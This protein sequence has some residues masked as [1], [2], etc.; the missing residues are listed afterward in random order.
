MNK[1]RWATTLVGAAVLAGA[2]STVSAQA[3][4]PAMNHER[5]AATMTVHHR[6][7][8][9][10]EFDTM[11]PVTGPFVGAANPIRG[12]PGGGLPWIIRAAHG[13]VQRD[14]HV[15]VEVRGLVLANQKVV[16]AALRRTNP[17]P[18]FRATISCLSVAKNDKAVVR[19]VMTGE[20][21][22]SKSGNSTIN[23]TVRLPRLCLAPE[24]F[25]TSPT[26]GNWF[27]V[28]GD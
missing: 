4:T 1:T 8:T 26:G 10:L 12:V 5:P 24:V 25:V 13:S 14:G 15:F 28:T 6:S 17:F 27:S 2:A 23:A 18:A 7:P 11:A 9:I 20:F 16:P 19:N 22:A 21:H 3:A